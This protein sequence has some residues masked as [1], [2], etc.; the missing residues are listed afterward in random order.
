MK[1]EQIIEKMSSIKNGTFGTV[2]YQTAL[3]VNKEAKKDGLQVIC[4]TKKMVRFGASYKNLV[5]NV[6]SSEVKPRQNNYTWILKDK[7]SHNS[8]TGK[9][10]IRISNINRKV[11]SKEYFILGDSG[12]KSSP[13][14][15]LKEFESLLQPS[16]LKSSGGSKPVVQNISI[17]NIISIN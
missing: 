16:Y 2:E 3:P 12:I 13:S 1:L 11:I 6:V 5:S 7:V 14:K 4:V 15:M 10:Y 9:D 8:S 17:D